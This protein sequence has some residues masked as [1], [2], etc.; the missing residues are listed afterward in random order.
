MNEVYEK[1]DNLNFNIVYYTFMCSNIPET[2]LK[3]GRYVRAYSNKF[4]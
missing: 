1:S 2:I 3:R 4:V